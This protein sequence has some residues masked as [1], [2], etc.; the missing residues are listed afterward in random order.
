[1]DNQAFASMRIHMAEKAL[2]TSGQWDRMREA[3][4]Y[5]SALQVLKETRFGALFPEGESYAVSEVLEKELQNQADFV[6]GLVHES[7]QKRL[8]FLHYDYH[9]L[10][11]LVKASTEPERFSPLFFPFGTLCIPRLKKQIAEKK[12]FGVATLA[13]KTAVEAAKVWAET[14]D[15]QKVDFL[16]DQA[17][18]AELQALSREIDSPF[19]LRYAQEMTDFT[20]L[21]SFFRARLQRQPKS[22]LAQVFLPG[23]TIRVEDLLSSKVSSPVTEDGSNA[24]SGVDHEKICAMLRRA[25]ASKETVRAWEA[26]AQTGDLNAVEKVRD[27]VAF[28]L[29]SEAG[30][31]ESGLALLFSYLVRVRTEIQDINI[32]LGA[33]RIGLPAEQIASHLRLTT[34]GMQME[35][36]RHA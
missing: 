9:N 34:P 7:D 13:E 29:A 28:L 31:K 27:R 2:I 4:D 20:N 16:L 36:S 33:K 18:F 19:F 21:L 3:P 15:A 24:L 5:D 23:G 12:T 11:I 35:R 17:Y 8:L 6:L 25:G 22:F 14:G 30:R 32:V 26:F 10:K 1:M